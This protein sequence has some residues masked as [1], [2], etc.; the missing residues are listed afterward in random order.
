MRTLISIDPGLSS[1]YVVLEYDEYLPP[2]L[3]ECAQFSGGAEEL[4]RRIK[5]LIERYHDA[6]IIC[7]DFTAR[8]LQG[9]SYKTRDLEPLVAIGALVA[10]GAIDRSDR[11]QMR[12]PQ[13]QYILGGESK[14]EKLKNRN[15]WFKEHKNLGYYITGKDVG[16]KDADDARSALAHCI[17]YLRREKHL[18]TL[19]LFRKDEN[20]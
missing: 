11:T 14:A 7:E 1:A 13:L 3:V 10:L 4:I 8:N 2:K 20:E 12:P 17:S 9:F 16:C 18:P 5:P 19:S 15:A 6:K